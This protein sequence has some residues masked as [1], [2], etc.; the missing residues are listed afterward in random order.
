MLFSYVQS[1]PSSFTPTDLADL[2]LWLDASDTA[3]ITGGSTASQWDDKS[4]NGYNATSSG[5]L[6]PS[7]GTRS[8]NSLNAMD[9]SGSNGMTL[10]AGFFDAIEASS[11]TVLIV[12]Q[13]DATT[14]QM[15]LL[16]GLVGTSTR[17]AIALNNTNNLFGLHSTSFSTVTA[18][19]TRDTNTHIAVFRRNG[20]SQTI[21]QDGT[22]SNNNASAVNNNMG[23][24]SI[25]YEAVGAG[26]QWYNGA[27][28]EIVACDADI[29][30]TSINETANYLASKWGCSWTDI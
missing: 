25:G 10:A 14:G 3:T 17:Y 9:F 12:Y 1:E 2:V 13:C 15:R 18:T 19:I 11:N 8:V 7:S 21:I 28:C 23:S 5:S 22:A 27:I 20:T 4:G 30:S 26:V 16:N 29:G 6:R 24:G